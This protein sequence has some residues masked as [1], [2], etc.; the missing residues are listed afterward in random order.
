MCLG[1]NVYGTCL[2]PTPNLHV[3][4]K[5]VFLDPMKDK[6]VKESACIDLVTESA[7]FKSIVNRANFSFQTQFPV[8]EWLEYTHYGLKS[9]LSKK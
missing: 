8:L 4:H 1:F 7:Q 6:R 2:L 5:Y 3:C 9:I